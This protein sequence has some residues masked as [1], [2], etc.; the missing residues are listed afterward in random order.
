M[1]FPENDDDN[2]IVHARKT[3]YF[4]GAMAIAVLAWI[5]W[6]LFF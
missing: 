4:L 3:I 1:P 5:A 6:M 2:G